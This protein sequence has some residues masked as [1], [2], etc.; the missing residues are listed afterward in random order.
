MIAKLEA[1]RFE[2]PDCQQ[3]RALL[4]AR[5]QV[6][7]AQDQALIARD[8]TIA[9]RDQALNRR[10]QDIVRQDQELNDKDEE[11][12]QLKKRVSDL[13]KSRHLA[14]SRVKTLTAK[15][16]VIFFFYIVLSL[17]V[18][19]RSE[20]I[21]AHLDGVPCAGVSPSASVADQTGSSDD[22]IDDTLVGD[23]VIRVHCLRTVLTLFF[24]VCRPQ[25]SS[26][27]G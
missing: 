15:W 12:R 18:L 9:E 25:Q 26:S 13:S 3:L 21:R 14:N 22:D 19:A 23:E 7:A 24:S 2:C 16:S 27:S 17:L 4:A 10:N 6:L 20:A 11:I 5:D 1:F 8:Q